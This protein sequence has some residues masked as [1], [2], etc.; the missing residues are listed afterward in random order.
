MSDLRCLLPIAAFSLT[1]GA[2][3]LSSTTA[4]ASVT[5]K[6]GIEI[7]GARDRRGLYLGPGLLFGAQFPAPDGFLPGV[8]GNFHIGGGVSQRLLLGANVGLVRYFAAQQ[9]VG[10]SGDIEVTGFITN[11][12]YL[13]GALG[14]AAMPVSGS[15]TAGMGG[16]AGAGY[17]LWLNQ[18]VAMDLGARYDLRA[19][20]GD[21]VDARH[22]VL[23][24]VRFTWY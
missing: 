16:A 23:L 8:A 15:L 19:V 24:G 9:S 18:T 10:L 11:G 22:S 1:L 6:Q 14:L 13:R 12:F 20:P 7:E 5:G 3:A 4:E 17:E 21:S 2:V